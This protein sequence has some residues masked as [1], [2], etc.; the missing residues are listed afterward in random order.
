MAFILLHMVVLG[1][2]QCKLETGTI[3]GTGTMARLTASVCMRLVFPSRRLLIA[4]VAVRRRVLRSVLEL[5]SRRHESG[6]RFEE[7]WL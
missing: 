3:I 1:D 7:H 6:S 4:L 2:L 5:F